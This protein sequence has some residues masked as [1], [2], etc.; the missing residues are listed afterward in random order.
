MSMGTMRMHTVAKNPETLEMQVMCHLGGKGM[1]SLLEGR[2]IPVAA[3]VSESHCQCSSEAKARI[4][5][6]QV[7][8]VKSRRRDIHSPDDSKIATLRS[9]FLYTSYLYSPRNNLIFPALL[10]LAQNGTWLAVCCWMDTS[11]VSYRRLIWPTSCGR[12]A[13][14]ADQGF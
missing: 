14:H 7:Q 4:A 10:L 9:E 13:K 3:V 12:T 8:R 5:I 11:G 2:P 1:C 6:L